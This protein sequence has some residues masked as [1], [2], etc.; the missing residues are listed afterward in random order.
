MMKKQA[1]GQRSRY[2]QMRG[3]WG[4]TLPA[5]LDQ[6]FGGLESPVAPNLRELEKGGG[7]RG[8]WMTVEILR[9]S[10]LKAA[11]AEQAANRLLRPPHR[12]RDLRRTLVLDDTALLVEHAPVFVRLDTA[13][14]VEDMLCVAV[15][16][17]W[18]TRAEDGPA[19]APGQPRRRAGIPGGVGE[20]PPGIDWRVAA[21]A[22]ALGHPGQGQRPGPSP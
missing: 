18:G 15:G 14:R 4:D 10:G 11:E 21:A 20:R 17:R 1:D 3:F 7:R 5:A 6:R 2:S 22:T 9:L 8:Q 13:A 19:A 12:T 16:P